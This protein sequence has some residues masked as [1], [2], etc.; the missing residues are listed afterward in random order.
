MKIKRGEVWW[1]N[2]KYTGKNI[3]YGERPVII[4]SNNTG[5]YYSNIVTVIPCT[6]SVKTQLPT[7]C[8]FYLNDVKN[9]ALCEQIL[10][11]NQNCLQE[12]KCTLSNDFMKILDNS[13]KVALG[14]KENF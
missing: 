1:C 13:I 5:N 14:L 2:L 4:I 8:D 6:S 3:Q 9:I 10:T 12:Y 7:H 11:I